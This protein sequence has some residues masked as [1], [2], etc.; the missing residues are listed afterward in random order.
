D[1][2][3]VIQV[4]L[5][6]GL[7]LAAIEPEPAAPLSEQV[8]VTTPPALEEEPPDIPVGEPE[9]SDEAAMEEEVEVEEPEPEPPPVQSVVDQPTQ[10]PVTDDDAADNGSGEIHSPATAGS[11]PFAG[12]TIDN[13]S[14]DYP[15]WFTQAFNKIR[16]NWRNPVAADGVIIC[17]V[18]FEVI[19]SGKVIV[20]RIENSSGIP[21]FDDACYAAVQRAAP[22]PPLPRQFADEIIGITLPFKYRP[23]M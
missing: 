6:S 23:G 14:F 13:A 10:P 9:T 19:K 2:D 20:I 21:R 1:Y 5:I 22:F 15:Y 18:Y 4:E 11:S 16:R 7:Q 17:A 3:D 12:A 8:E